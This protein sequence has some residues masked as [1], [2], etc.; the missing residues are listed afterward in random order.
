MADSVIEKVFD[1]AMAGFGATVPMT[2]AMELMHRALPSHEQYPLPPRQ[3]TMRAAEGAGVKHHL[4][5]SDRLGAT[6]ASH[7]GYGAVTG[8]VYAA[9]ADKINISPVV[10]G[11]GFGLAVWAVSYLGI[12]P[13][14][15]ALSP[16]TKHPARRN[17]LMIAAHVVW[18]GALG[19]LT[20]T[21][22][23][24]GHDKMEVRDGRR[25]SS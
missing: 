24:E 20:E 9:K 21:F 16:A 18:G 22:K 15:G 12:L 2:I 8:A 6:L 19:A 25:K 11:I 3:I 4:N 10:K 7:F 17:A 23:K 13:A 5:E 1:G 14:V